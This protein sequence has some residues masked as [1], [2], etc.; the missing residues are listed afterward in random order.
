MVSG[1]SAR[2]E[3]GSP[4]SYDVHKNGVA[5]HESPGR[6]GTITKRSAPLHIRVILALQEARRSGRASNLR[7]PA[8]FSESW[9]GCELPPVPTA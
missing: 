4:S 3:T 1:V 7:C 2:M 8:Y 9:P 6:F 5:R